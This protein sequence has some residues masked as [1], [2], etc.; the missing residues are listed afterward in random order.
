MTRYRVLRRVRDA[1]A[2][3]AKAPQCIVLV[4]GPYV[5][6]S[7]ALA[8]MEAIVGAGLRLAL[9]LLREPSR[10]ISRFLHQV[11]L[12]RGEDAAWEIVD[13]LDWERVP[14]SSTV[15][16]LS[17]GGFYLE[18]ERICPIEDAHGVPSSSLASLYATR[19]P[20]GAIA[21]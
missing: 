11:H 8:H 21:R 18:G 19:M 20:V 10:R 9:V 17:S 1:Q 16:V 13:H 5:P 3:R 7:V 2:G 14:R 12:W 6:D 15:A 4:C